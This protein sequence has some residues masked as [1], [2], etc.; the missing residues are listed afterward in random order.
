MSDKE[1]NEQKTKKELN[2]KNS[3][4]NLFD[5]CNNENTSPEEKLQLFFSNKKIY[6]EIYNGAENCS[7]IYYNILSNSKH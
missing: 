7:K 4:N 2:S 6:I 5:F 1:S 3:K